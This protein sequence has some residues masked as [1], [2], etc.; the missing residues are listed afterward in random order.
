MAKGGHFNWLKMLGD[1]SGSKAWEGRQVAAGDSARKGG[2]DGRHQGLMVPRSKVRLCAHGVGAGAG[3]ERAG[4]RGYKFGRQ[5]SEGDNVHP[6]AEIALGGEDNGA[7]PCD[8]SVLTAEG[9]TTTSI[10]HLANREK[11]ERLH[12][13][14]DMRGAG[15]GRQ[16]RKGQVAPT[17][18]VHDGSGG[19]ADAQAGGGGVD[20]EGAPS[21]KEVRSAPGVEDCPV[22]GAGEAL[23]EAIDSPRVRTRG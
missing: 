5:G 19:E 12:R 13:R 1:Q 10:A 22:V 4:E 23:G 17:A 9:D 8:D 21:T 15:A 18:G 7:E 11:G 14:K 2:V 3:R 6:S 16:A 20:R